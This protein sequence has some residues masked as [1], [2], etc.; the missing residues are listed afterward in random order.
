MYILRHM[1]I[2]KKKTLT[3]I[4]FD[5]GK[6]RIFF[7]A[8]VTRQLRS[9]VAQE[10]KR[11]TVNAMGCGILEE[12]KHLFFSFIALVTETKGGVEFCYSTRND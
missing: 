6:L 2:N 3:I 5:S 1:Y 7:F 9:V 12:I 8:L 11:A 10:R 4:G